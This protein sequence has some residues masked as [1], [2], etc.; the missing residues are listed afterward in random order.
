MDWFQI[1]RSKETKEIP[2][3]FSSE[4]KEGGEKDHVIFIWDWIATNSI[5]TLT[6]E[7]GHI[8]YLV[9]HDIY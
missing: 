6:N 1:V 5:W 7:L 4:N 8:I 3:R 2:K 9:L